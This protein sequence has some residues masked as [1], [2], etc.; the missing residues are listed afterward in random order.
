MVATNKALTGVALRIL[1]LMLSHVDGDNF[2]PLTP[3]RIERLLST[4]P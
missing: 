2:I 3:S 1:F 4:Y